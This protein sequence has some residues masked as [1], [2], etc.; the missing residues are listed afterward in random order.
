LLTAPLPPE[1]TFSSSA[2]EPFS[3]SGPLVIWDLGD[4]GV[5]GGLGTITLTSAVSESVTAGDRLPIST[6]L[7]CDSPEINVANNEY[8]VE[9]FVSL[10]LILSFITR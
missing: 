3:H 4:L 7:E 1:V 2:P 10:Q 8:Q 6:F 5:E 9:I